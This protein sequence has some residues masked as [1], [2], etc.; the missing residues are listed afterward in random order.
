MCG[1]FRGNVL[2]KQ[3]SLFFDDMNPFFLLL[4]ND[5]EHTPCPVGNPTGVMTQVLLQSP[6]NVDNTFSHFF[7]L[8][9]PTSW[10]PR[11]LKRQHQGGP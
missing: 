2:S 10:D 3:D 11:G 4:E 5:E 8:K 1:I 7:S 6:I 9:L